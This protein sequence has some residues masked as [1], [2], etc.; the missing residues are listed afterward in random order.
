MNPFRTPVPFWGQTTQFLSSLSPERDCNSKQMEL[1]GIC[2]AQTKHTTGR[3]ST[4]Q[5]STV[6]DWTGLLGGGLTSTVSKGREIRTLTLTSARRWAASEIMASDPD[7]MPPITSTTKKISTNVV[8]RRSFL[9]GRTDGPPHHITSAYTR[10]QL[11]R[12]LGEHQG[13][14]SDSNT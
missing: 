7:Q 3:D 8:A 5:Y 2:R 4:G 1:C 6:Q 14:Y 10:Q 12:V 11:Q 9:H 13:Q